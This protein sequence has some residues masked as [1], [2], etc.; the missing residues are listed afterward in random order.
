MLTPHIPQISK[1][2]LNLTITFQNQNE[3]SRARIIRVD[4]SHLRRSAVS[5]VAANLEKLPSVLRALQY[6]D[7]LR[8]NSRT[9]RQLV[10]TAMPSRIWISKRAWK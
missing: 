8:R 6:H 4:L 3:Q 9:S 10:L 2:K 7:R 5:S 1:L